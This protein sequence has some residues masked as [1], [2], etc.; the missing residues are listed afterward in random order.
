MK[1]PVPKEEYADINEFME[2]ARDVMAYCMKYSHLIFVR[3]K[4][5]GGQWESRS[6][7]S[8]N[9]IE[10][11]NYIYKFVMRNTV[12]ARI[13]DSKERDEGTPEEI[14]KERKFRQITEVLIHTPGDICLEVLGMFCTGCGT[15]NDPSEK[16]CQCWNDE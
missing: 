5:E 14:E 16:P 15:Y 7:A 4:E 11:A 1:A 3:H 9:P 10:A 6:L 13:T 2:W 12:P 8:L